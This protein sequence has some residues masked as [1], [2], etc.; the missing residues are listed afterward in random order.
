MTAESG[1]YME[2]ADVFEHCRLDAE[3]SEIHGMFC[4]ILSSHV[5]NPDAVWQ[6]ELLDEE[7]KGGPCRQPLK[8]LFDATKESITGPGLGFTPLLPDDGA[9][10]ADRTRALASWVAGFLYGLG[11]GG[12]ATDDLG[13]D[14][15]EVLRDLSDFGRVEA[16][17]SDTEENEEAYAELVEYLWVAVMLVYAEVEEQK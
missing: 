8:R 15:R 17:V 3:P 10:L 12:L 1:T 7:D 5:E 14:A 4:G 6:Q 2:Y 9:A 13:D 16:E 11:L